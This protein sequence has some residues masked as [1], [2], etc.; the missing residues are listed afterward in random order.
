MS[1]KISPLIAVRL[2]CRQCSGESPKEVALC[3][4]PDCALYPFRFGHNPARKGIT[5]RSKNLIPK[6]TGVSKDF[7]KDK[8]V[9]DELESGK[10]SGVQS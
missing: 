7:H 4:I 2:Y 8:V 9:K 1:K 3:T 10:G 5:G 6:P